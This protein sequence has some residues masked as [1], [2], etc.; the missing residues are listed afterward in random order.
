MSKSKQAALRKKDDDMEEVS[1]E[2]IEPP[3]K[4]GVEEDGEFDIQ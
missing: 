3:I 1:L 2:Q 4:P